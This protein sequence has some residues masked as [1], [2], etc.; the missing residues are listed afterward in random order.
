MSSM[1]IVDDDRSVRHLIQAA[2]RDSDFT[3]FNAATAQ[4]G[5]TLLK[6]ESPDVILLDIMLPDMSGLEAFH[7]IHELA[8]RVPVIF[9]TSGGA[10]ETA[11]EAMKLGAFDYL[12]KPL[13]TANVQHLV[14]QAVDSYR[15][16]AAVK[17]E[18]ADNAEGVGE[19]LI[20]RSPQ[21]QEVYK[22]IGRVASQD[23]TVLIRGESGSGKE[24]V[25]RALC[26]H[27][28]RARKPFLAVN[29]AALTE[30]LLESELFGHERGAFTGAMSQRIGKFEQCSGGTLFM[31]EV[32]DMAPT[33]Q[34][35]VLRV[36]QEQ[37][38]E[39]VGGTE[40][41][42][43]DVRVIAATNRDL[44]KM[45]SEGEFRED[46]YYRINGFTLRI[47]PLRDRKDDILI[48]LD[49]FLARFRRE[50]GKDVQGLAPDA[51]DV[52]LNYR[53]PGNVR[54][55]QNALKQAMLNAN[56][57]VLIAEF[58]PP[59]LR[60]APSPHYAEHATVESEAVSGP[61]PSDLAPSVL[62]GMRSGSHD[63][64]AETIAVME[65]Y[66]LPAVL[67]HTEGNQSKAADVLGITRGSLR[68]KIRAH[69]ISLGREIKLSDEDEEPA[70]VVEGTV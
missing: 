38:F 29:C 45:V 19:V 8:P 32:G 47:P 68:N 9:I 49:W 52:L 12:L 51:V 13:E 18:R 66:L 35:K 63:L 62:Q 6:N 39:R 53:W 54:Q 23:V 55:L 16:S 34:S 14:R 26:Q 60:V 42:Q 37:R 44:E 5:L 17:L 48:L 20:G 69:A 22:A 21:M 65:R 40:T 3:I 58:L 56:G 43:T 7:K 4:D 57:P 41:I 24:L 1:L 70:P 28:R 27:S 59:E 25:A 15:L 36:L 64:Y 67:R 11:I 30:S 10:S 2:M 50:L 61:A 33:M 31:D 46:L